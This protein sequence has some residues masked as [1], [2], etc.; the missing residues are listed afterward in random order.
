MAEPDHSD[1]D[2]SDVDHSESGQPSSGRS[3]SARSKKNDSNSAESGIPQ[4][5]QVIRYTTNRSRRSNLHR[6]RIEYVF[7]GDEGDTRSYEPVTGE[8]DGVVEVHMVP[9]AGGNVWMSRKRVALLAPRGL[10][11]PEGVEEPYHHIL[12]YL[13][14]QKPRDVFPARQ[15]HTTSQHRGKVFPDQPR[16]FRGGR[17][18]P[19][20]SSP[21]Q[22]SPE[23]SPLHQSPPP[24]NPQQFPTQALHSWQHSAQSQQLSEG[25]SSSDLSQQP[26]VGPINPVSLSSNNMA[27]EE[28]AQYPSQGHQVA[29]Q[30][31]NSTAAPA[32]LEA[33]Q[34][35]YQPGIDFPGF[36][37]GP[38]VAYHQ[39]N[40][41]SAL[42]SAF[43]QFQQPGVIGAAHYLNDFGAANYGGLS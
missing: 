34:L 4:D 32:Q 33:P 19:E 26:Q 8:E 24:Q 25:S 5:V 3:L 42:S 13:P 9:E 41:A 7:E 43:Y 27:D 37:Q 12:L 39:G 36:D 23:Q 14:D 20:Q 35:A 21:E 18:P 17:A 1:E 40:D 38:Q 31:T 22:S 28:Q 11:L 29:Y 10:V 30:R 2:H 15:W 16:Q 6:P